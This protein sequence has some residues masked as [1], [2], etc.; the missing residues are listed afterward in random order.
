MRRVPPGRRRY[1]HLNKVDYTTYSSAFARVH[2]L[3]NT[4]A[5]VF[6]ETLFL[7]RIKYFATA[8]D[9]AFGSRNID[10][11][12]AYAGKAFLS[13]HI[14][15]LCD[16]AGLSVD[17]CTL[18]ESLTALKAG[19]EPSRIGLHGNNKSSEEILLAVERQFARIILDSEEEIGRVCESVAMLNALPTETDAARPNDARPL[20][21]NVFLRVT[22]GVHA[23]G[24]EFISTAHEDQKFGVS[25]AKGRALQAL[26][27]IL[28]HPELHLQ[29]IH[30][31]IGS[32]IVDDRAF[33]ESAQKMLQ[34]RTDLHAET[35]YLLPEIDL[36]GGFG[37][38]YTSIDP[39]LDLE[40]LF[41]Q[42]AMTIQKHCEESGEA[43]PK[44]SFEPGRYLMAPCMTTVYSVG[45]VK[46][47]EYAPGKFRRYI[48]VDGGMSDNIRPIL[49]G[50]K[51]T[52]F[53]LPGDRDARD[54]EADGYILSRVVG[55][56]CESGDILISETYLPESV[57][58]G[59]LLCIPVTGAYS[60]SMAS[61]YNMLPKPAVLRL[62]KTSEEGERGQEK[63]CVMIPQQHFEDLLC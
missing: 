1:I 52:C 22:N 32:Q 6:D 5:L 59:D 13:T 31:H 19:L 9:K 40:A 21:A 24:H 48:A 25:L 36:G 23:G 42:I 46:D 38:Q 49:Y 55:K 18:F 2:E 51:Y 50:A 61:N 57:Q 27:N 45:S 4:P 29:G 11:E 3:S 7:E 56:H 44:I 33:V 37:V 34:L 43:L 58:R 62:C 10:T 30:A 12:I 14:V 20:K 35:G 47:V 54:T 16:K 53:V 28:E 60:Y 8:L 63:L 17:T 41:E 15:K 39:E 26:R